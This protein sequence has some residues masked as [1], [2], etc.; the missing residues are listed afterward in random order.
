MAP[1]ADVGPRQGGL[2]EV[3]VNSTKVDI[4]AVVESTQTTVPKV[5]VV[6]LGGL[7]EGRARTAGAGQVV[8]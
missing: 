1:L 2:R 4:S 6:W 8:G 5:D 7:R 3:W